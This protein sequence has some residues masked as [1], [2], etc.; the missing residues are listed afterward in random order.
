ME[1]SKTVKERGFLGRHRKK[2]VTTAAVI[3]ILGI[4]AGASYNAGKK[5]GLS[6]R[7][8]TVATTSDV[9]QKLKDAAKNLPKKSETSGLNGATSSSGFFRLS[10][11][12]TSVKNDTITIKLADGTVLA[13]TTAKDAKFYTGTP[14]TAKPIRE[15]KTGTSAFV[16]GTIAPTGTF[17]ASTIQVQ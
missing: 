5:Q 9:I 6:Q 14:R 4:T 17:K 3:A 16:I 8:G 10:G 12:I 11:T 13:L 7:I 2:L 1:S 15:L